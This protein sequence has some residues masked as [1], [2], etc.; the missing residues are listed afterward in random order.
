M[1]H[2]RHNPRS[3]EM[4]VS[5]API[6][7]AFRNTSS[8]LELKT[9]ASASNQAPTIKSPTTKIPSP[10]SLEA[11]VKDPV[12][13]Y[14]AKESAYK[15]SSKIGKKFQDTVNLIADKLIKNRL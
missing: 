8:S 6:K 9:Q 10:Y 7:T 2:L 5:T 3:G 4:P 14:L 15:P 11:V 1:N 12:L 13:Y